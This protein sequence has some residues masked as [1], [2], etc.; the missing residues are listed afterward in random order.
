LKLS[1]KLGGS[2][3]VLKQKAIIKDEIKENKEYL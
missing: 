1:L 2:L 3:S